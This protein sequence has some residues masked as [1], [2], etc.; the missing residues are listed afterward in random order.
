MSCRDF[1]TIKLGKQI[2]VNDSSGNMQEICNTLRY[3]QASHSENRLLFK[4]AE[5]LLY[6]RH[7]AS[8]GDV[9]R[10]KTQIMP[11]KT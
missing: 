7:Y 2:A 9:E 4:C 11:L 6:D 1:L 3:K 10:S 8:H 5:H